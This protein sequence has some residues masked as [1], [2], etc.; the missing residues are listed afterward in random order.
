[1]SQPSASL[2]LTKIKSYELNEPL[3][4]T[5]QIVDTSENKKKRLEVNEMKKNKAF[6][7]I[8]SLFQNIFMTFISTFFIGTNLSIITI[9]LYG[10]NLINALNNILNVNKSFAQYESVEYSL[11]QYKILYLILAFINLGAVGYKINKM[12]LLPLSAADWVSL[13][14][15]ILNEQNT[16]LITK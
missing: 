10:Y 4:F 16:I 13:T 15:V 8:T 11:L 2:D 12:G 5:A 6:G 3:G 9:S 7:L 1:M 14:N